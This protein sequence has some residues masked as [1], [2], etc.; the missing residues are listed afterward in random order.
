VLRST[1]K[2]HLSRVIDSVSAVVFSPDGQLLASASRDSTVRLWDSR[3]GASRGT[4]KGYSG[5]VSAVV[6]SLD[7]PLLASASDDNTVR[8]WDVQTKEA[9]QIFST[10]GSI[11]CLFFS[12][13]RPY[14][15][16]ERGL[17][18]LNCVYQQFDFLLH[19]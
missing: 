10:K 14:L 5:S 3:M 13:D 9:I 16:T 15:K 1:L 17:F 6:F 19:L 7:G 11:K 18:K 4:L 8:L 12:S 2:G